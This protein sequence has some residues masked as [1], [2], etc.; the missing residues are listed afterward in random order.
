MQLTRQQ[1]IDITTNV[2]EYVRI[3][4]LYG[5]ARKK[6]HQ[7]VINRAA[8]QANFFCHNK[9]NGK[10]G[11]GVKRMSLKKWPL[12]LVDRPK[13]KTDSSVTGKAQTRGKRT[14]RET[15]SFGN[16]GGLKGFRS[17][18]WHALASGLRRTPSNH[19]E[20]YRGVY[21]GEGNLKE[22]TRIFERRADK[23]GA[24]AAGFLVGARKMGLKN[25]GA[26]DA[27]PKAGGSASRSTGAKATARL[28]ASSVNAVKGS[29]EV[30]RETMERAIRFVLKDMEGHALK[31][32]QEQNDKAMAKGGLK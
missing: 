7:E 32:L 19:W 15:A 22:A 24:M 31:L 17:A 5:K 21:R 29:Y 8:A 13:R 27:Q 23:R 12:R 20:I 11:G 6:T 16:K 30:G 3:M 2:P 14:R 9:P 28:K 4:D 10:N 18:F 26:K 1:F 25:K